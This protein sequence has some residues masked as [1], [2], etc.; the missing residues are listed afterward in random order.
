ME[1]VRVEDRLGLGSHGGFTLIET[2]VA[3]AIL[4]ISLT[5][6]FQLFSGGLKSSRL[7]DEYTS[8]IF[9]SR[10]KMEEILLAEELTDGVTEGEFEDGFRWRAE[11]L[12]L[13]PEE[14]V[15]ARLP[16]DTI[17]INLDIEWDAG[18]S[19]KHFEISTIKIA[20]KLKNSGFE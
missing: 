2:L 14:E 18:R 13:E 5:V 16:F 7:S 3:I 17:S 10:E 6:I 20:E 12:R 1:R 9:H 4:S 11:I 8:G 19:T 15:E